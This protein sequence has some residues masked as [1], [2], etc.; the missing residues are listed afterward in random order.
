M[1]D[2]LVGDELGELFELGL[3]FFGLVRLFVIEA[4]VEPGVGQSRVEALDLFEESDGFGDSISVEQ[5]E[6]VVEFFANGGGREVERL[7]ELGDGFDV[8][9]GVFEEGFAQ[10]AMAFYGCVGC[11]GKGARREPGEKRGCEDRANTQQP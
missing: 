6:C 9:G 4:E 2:R 10:I 11:G 5:G 1:G 7:L 3:R 8:G